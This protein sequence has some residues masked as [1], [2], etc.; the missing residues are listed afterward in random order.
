LEDQQINELRTELIDKFI[1]LETF[2][3]AVITQHYFHQISDKFLF[4]VLYDE[5]FSFSLKHNILKKITQ[6]PANK[7][8]EKLHRIGQIRNYFAHRGRELV[9]WVG[10]SRRVRVIDPRKLDH[11]I[12]FPKLYKEFCDLER[13]VIQYLIKVFEEKGGR[14]LTDKE[15]ENLCRNNR[16]CSAAGS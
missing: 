2:V 4:E 1:N 3:D 16:K 13:P 8:L 15:I 7:V 6:P 5:N 14:F 11:E 10:T 9:D 12:D